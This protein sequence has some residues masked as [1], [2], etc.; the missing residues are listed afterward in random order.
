MCTTSL[1]TG[2]KG[3]SEAAWVKLGP[4]PIESGCSHS[5][6]VRGVFAALRRDGGLG[7]LDA[8]CPKQ[9]LPR[10]EEDDRFP[11]GLL[12]EGLRSTPLLLLLLL[13]LGPPVVSPATIAPP[14]FSQST[15]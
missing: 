2:G 3:F 8:R 6:G 7:L 10:R 1:E 4:L 15:G 12:E 5:L 11:V 13:R 14:L 9:L